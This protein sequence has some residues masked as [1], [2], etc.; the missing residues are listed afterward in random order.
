MQLGPDVDRSMHLG[1]EYVIRH[2]EVDILARGARIQ[3]IVCARVITVR[4]QT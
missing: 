3:F 4:S 2:R 1:M